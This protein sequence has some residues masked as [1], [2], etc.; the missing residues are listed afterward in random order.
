[1][2]QSKP[3][4][5]NFIVTRFEELTRLASATQRLLALQAAVSA[6]EK[7]VEQARRVKV[8]TL[9]S[10]TAAGTTS[11]DLFITFSVVAS[12]LI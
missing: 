10:A 8:A 3:G 7:A 2:Y 12:C 11:S 9:S 6:R 4:C 5:L 1:M